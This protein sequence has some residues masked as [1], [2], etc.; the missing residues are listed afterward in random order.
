M[1]SVLSYAVFV[2]PLCNLA[3]YLN[4]ALSSGVFV[5]SLLPGPWARVPSRF[6]KSLCCYHTVILDLSCFYYSNLFLCESFD[7]FN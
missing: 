5:V 7:K 1:S 2:Y 6:I 4:A 3:S